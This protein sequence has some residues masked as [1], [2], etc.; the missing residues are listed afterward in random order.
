[1]RY[2]NNE[3]TYEFFGIEPSTFYAGKFAMSSSAP[4]YLAVSQNKFHID[5][6]RAR[7]LVDNVAGVRVLDIGC[8]SAPFGKT[9]RNNA[10]VE[11]IYGVDLDPQCVEIAKEVY[12]FVN[13]FDLNSRLPFD[14]GYFDC[15]FSMDVLGHIEF[16][17]KDNLL[18]EICR[19]TKSGGCSVHG[20][21]CGVVDY[22]KANPSDENCPITKYVWQDGHVGVE[23]ANAL[24][25]RWE[26]FFSD[27]M[28]RN[29]FVWPLL[30][31]LAIQ[32][33]PM[34]K[35]LKEI[36]SGYNH[37]QI[38][39]VQVVLG[40]LQ[41]EYR[42]HIEK[43]DSSLLFPDERYPFSKHCGFVYLTAAKV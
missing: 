4:D 26:S 22:S 12:D 7:F 34:P 39:A 17:S 40:F 13:V 20:I 36:L 32:H 21:E 15:V 35:E 16:K 5:C 29:A 10:R 27:V 18:R 11:K 38:E 1:M 2:S 43:T 6:D 42:K 33:M 24:K 8:G 19:V 28:I 41:S 25:A 37:S 14:D 30:P 3:I 31:F 23:D 9:I